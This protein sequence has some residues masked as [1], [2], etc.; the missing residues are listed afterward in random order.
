MYEGSPEVHFWDFR[1]FF[2]P[3]IGA[4]RWKDKFMCFMCVVSRPH[5][6]IQ[7]S[8]PQTT[9]CASVSQ[10]WG[11]ISLTHSLTHLHAHRGKETQYHT[12]TRTHTHTHKT[13]L[14]V[15][16]VLWVDC[17]ILPSNQLYLVFLNL[18]TS[19]SACKS[20]LCRYISLKHRQVERHT[21]THTYTQTVK[22]NTQRKG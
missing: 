15:L 9:L 3:N 5:L 22:K 12:H 11:H 8:L 4:W 1:H 2:W 7:P 20:Q 18:R 10:L 14:R 17:H 16:C 21:H 6:P 13:S 19:L